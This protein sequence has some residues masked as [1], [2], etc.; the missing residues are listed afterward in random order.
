MQKGPKLNTNKKEYTNLHKTNRFKTEKHSL[1]A[2]GGPQDRGRPLQGPTRG[3]PLLRL[4][5]SLDEIKVERGPFQ[6]IILF[7]LD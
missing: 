1:R 2:L 5:D 6:W 7:Y 3:P 4:R